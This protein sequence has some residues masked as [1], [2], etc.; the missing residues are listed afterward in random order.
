[1]LDTIGI[2]SFL[3][4][5]YITVVF[6]PS[7]YIGTTDGERCNR[8]DLNVHPYLLRALDCFGLLIGF[9]ALLCAGFLPFWVCFAGLI[10]SAVCAYGSGFAATARLNAAY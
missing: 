5:A 8:P 7:F 4:L 1:M 6:L 2:A 9:S 3:L 10:L